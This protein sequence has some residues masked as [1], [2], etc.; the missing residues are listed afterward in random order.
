VIG[1]GA[2][3][4]ALA[5]VGASGGGKVLLWARAPEVVEAVHGDLESKVVLAGHRLSNGIRATGELADLAGCDA[6]LVVTPAQHMRSVLEAAPTCDKPLI[7]CSKGIEE[8][9]GSLL[10]D[11]AAETSLGAAIAI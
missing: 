1:G 7:L 11:A 10:H 2:W 9:S 3:G 5:Q 6:W 4:T 8:R